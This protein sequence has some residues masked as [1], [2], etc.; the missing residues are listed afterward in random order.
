M[1]KTDTAIGEEHEVNKTTASLNMM[2]CN[3]A[4]RSTFQRKLSPV[5]LHSVTV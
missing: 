1:R 2:R 3:V 4:G 5:K